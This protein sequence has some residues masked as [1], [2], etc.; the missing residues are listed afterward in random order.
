MPLMNLAWKASFFWDGRAPSLRE[1]VL[2]P[3]E[4][5]LEMHES[6]SNVVQKLRAA[7]KEA[8][9]TSYRLRFARAFGSGEV[10]PERITRALEQFV[11]TQTSYDSKFDRVLG[12]AAELTDEEKRG[13]ELFHTE[14]DPR[15][16]LYGADCFHCHGGPLFQSQTF[17]NNGLDARFADSGRMEVTRQP[18]DRGKFAVPSLRNV[19]VTAPYM[20]D[21]R[22]A[23]L[24]QV[25]EHYS[26]GVQ[27]SATLDP[28]LAKHPDGGVPM[29]SADKKALVSFL[30][31]L[32]DERYRAA[33]VVANSPR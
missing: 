19:E 31:T 30:K 11:I 17:A 29:T 21:G 24:E 5:A 32:T 2:M 28:N 16:G 10:T 12:G 23:T 22:F 6:L 33:A 9:T 26:A 20:H 27:R 15:R 4:N 18:G 14:Y 25:I 3:I 7:D 13:F 1:Q 8:K